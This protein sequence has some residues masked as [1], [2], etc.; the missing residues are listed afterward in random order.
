MSAGPVQT[1]IIL[2]PFDAGSPGWAKDV[3]PPRHHKAERTTRWQPQKA[4]PVTDSAAR[5]EL[6]RRLLGQTRAQSER[7]LDQAKAMLRAA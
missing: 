4:I 2:V 6:L 3:K 7:A 5:R 1:Q